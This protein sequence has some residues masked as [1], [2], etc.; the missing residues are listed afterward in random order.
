M[1]ELREQ[2]AD[3]EADAVIAIDI[4]YQ[5]LSGGGKSGMLLVVATGTAVTIRR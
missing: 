3:L 4:D 2:A 1:E 5:E